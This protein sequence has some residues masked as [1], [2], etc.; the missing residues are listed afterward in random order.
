M[1]KTMFTLI[2]RGTVYTPEKIGEKE[3]AIE[4]Y[5]KIVDYNNFSYYTFAAQI[6]LERLGQTAELKEINTEVY[7]DNPE[8]AELLPD[9][10]GETGEPGDKDSETGTDHDWCRDQ[11]LTGGLFKKS[12]DEFYRCISRLREHSA[13]SHAGI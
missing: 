12:G 2:K 9:I 13:M 3:Q 11:Y 8:I 1:E 10:F 5:K 4:S 6:A 7:P